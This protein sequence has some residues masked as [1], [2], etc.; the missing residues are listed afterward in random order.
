MSCILWVYSVQWPDGVNAAL[1]ARIWMDENNFP[2]RMLHLLSQ[3]SPAE[4]LRNIFYCSLSFLFWARICKRLRSPGI[5][6]ASLRI[7]WRAGTTNRVIIVMARQDTKAGWIESM[8]SIPGLLKG[9]RQRE[10][11]EAGNVSNCPNLPRTSAIDQ[12][13]NFAVV[14][15]FAYFRFRPSTAKWI[16]IVLPNRRNAV[17]R[18]MFFFLL[19]TAHCLLTHRVI[20]RP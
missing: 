20:L 19:Y 8:E 4:I 12:S 17:I 16:G 6:S 11:R 9:S 3:K 2:P 5:D 1:S 7:A 18:S 10:S 14:F 13:I 15:D